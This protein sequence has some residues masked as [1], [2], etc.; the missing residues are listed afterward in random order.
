MVPVSGAAE[1]DPGISTSDY[2]YTEIGLTNAPSPP[3]DGTW[4][5]C[6]LGTCDEMTV[7]APAP[8]EAAVVLSSQDA[9]PNKVNC[10]F[11]ISVRQQYD[12][13]GG[14]YDPAPTYTWGE[15]IEPNRVRAAA[16]GTVFTITPNLTADTG[17]GLTLD[18][19]TGEISGTPAD[20]S[21]PVSCVRSCT[22]EES[23]S[24]SLGLTAVGLGRVC[25][26]GTDDWEICSGADTHCLS[27][28]Y[29]GTL[30]RANYPSV[31][32]TDYF[33]MCGDEN[34]CAS[35]HTSLTGDGSWL[36]GSNYDGYSYAADS[37]SCNVTDRSASAT[38]T[39]TVTA[40]ND[41]GSASAAIT[42]TIVPPLPVLSSSCADPENVTIG[43]ATDLNCFAASPHTTF[44]TDP[45]LPWA[46]VMHPHTGRIN[47]TAHK[48]SFPDYLPALTSASS[49]PPVTYTVRATNAAGEVTTP[50]NLT[51]ALEPPLLNYSKN[52][53]GVLKCLDGADYECT[54]GVWSTLLKEQSIGD[55]SQNVFVANWG[56]EATYSIQ[57]LNQPG[58]SDLPDGLELSTPYPWAPGTQCEKTFPVLDQGA[59][60]DSS[61]RS[62]Q[63]LRQCHDTKP[64]EC[65]Q[66]Y[67]TAT[68]SRAR[69]TYRITARNAAGESTIDVTFEVKPISRN[70]RQLG[71]RLPGHMTDAGFHNVVGNFE[72]SFSQAVNQ[73]LNESRIDR[74]RIAS[75]DCASDCV[76]PACGP[77]CGRIEPYGFETLPAQDGIGITTLIRFEICGGDCLWRKAS[78]QDPVYKDISSVQIE[79]ALRTVIDTMLGIPNLMPADAGTAKTRRSTILGAELLNNSAIGSGHTGNDIVRHS[80]DG[81]SYWTDRYGVANVGLESGLITFG[82]NYNKE[83]P[84]TPYLRLPL[85]D[86]A[87]LNTNEIT[88]TQPM[89]L[90]WKNR[91]LCIDDPNWCSPPI[92]D[93]DIETGC[94]DNVADPSCVPVV[95]CKGGEEQ[96]NELGCGSKYVVRGDCAD[97]INNGQED[98][99]KGAYPGFCLRQGDLAVLMSDEP[100]DA[101]NT[102]LDPSHDNAEH[103]PRPSSDLVTSG[104]SAGPDV[105]GSNYPISLRP[106]VTDNGANP[107][108]LDNADVKFG[109]I[110]FTVASMAEGV[111]LPRDAKLNI[112]LNGKQY[113]T[114]TNR[115]LTQ[116]RENTD[117]DGAILGGVVALAEFGPSGFQYVNAET[118]T[119]TSIEPEALPLRRDTV[120]T[121]TGTTFQT[122]EANVTVFGSDGQYIGQFNSECTGQGTTQRVCDL[123]QLGESTY[124]N[125][126]RIEIKAS[127][128]QTVTSVADS[129]PPSPPPPS[130]SP[131]P[132]EAGSGEEGSGSGFDGGLEDEEPSP[133]AP[134]P[135]SAPPEAREYSSIL[136][137][138]ESA[139]GTLY[140]PPT[141]SSFQPTVAPV[142]RPLLIAVHGSGFERFDS[143]SR[144][145]NPRPTPY[146]GFRP[147]DDEHPD[148][149]LSAHG[150]SDGGNELG[151]KVTWV[152]ALHSGVEENTVCGASDPNCIACNV[153]EQ[154]DSAQPYAVY[155]SLNA[156]EENNAGKGVFWNGVNDTFFVFSRETFSPYGTVRNAS[157]RYDADGEPA[158]T[159]PASEVQIGLSGF[160]ND[161]RSEA[162]PSSNA[163][164][165]FKDGTTEEIVAASAVAGSDSRLR[166]LS[167]PW[168][169]TGNIQ[170]DVSLDD[171]VTFSSFVTSCT[172]DVNTECYKYYDSPVVAEVVPHFGPA[173]GGAIIKLKNNMTLLPDGFTETADGV[174]CQF[175]TSNPVVGTRDS[176]E[177]VR[178]EAPPLSTGPHPVKVSLNGQLYTLSQRDFTSFSLS[179]SV[180]W[181][182]PRNQ[183]TN[184]TG[185]ITGLSTLA[186]ADRPEN[187]YC[188]FGG[189]QASDEKAVVSAE[190]S[191]DAIQIRCTAPDVE[192]TCSDPS[193][194]KAQ[195]EVEMSGYNSS[196]TGTD[197]TSNRQK[198]QYYDQPV[199]GTVMPN[200]TNSLG[201]G[202]VEVSVVASTSEGIKEHV[203]TGGEKGTLKC[204]F[205]PVGS[206]GTVKEAVGTAKDDGRAVRCQQPELTSAGEYTVEVSLNDQQ[207]TTGGP[208]LRAFRIAPLDSAVDGAVMPRG[209]P[210][211]SPINVRFKLQGLPQNGQGVS[212]FCQLGN[213]TLPINM[214]FAGSDT[215]TEGLALGEPPTLWDCQLP[216]LDTGMVGLR[217]LFLS[218]DADYFD[219]DA[220]PS[221]PFH[222]YDEPSVYSLSPTVV[223]GAGTGVDAVY[224]NGSFPELLGDLADSAAVRCVFGK[225]Q[226]VEIGSGNPPAD[227]EQVAIGDVS[228]V[229]AAKLNVTGG[230]VKCPITPHAY[231]DVNVWVTLDGAS[232]YPRPDGFRTN[233]D[234][235]VEYNES[236]DALQ[237]EYEGCPQG[238]FA[239]QPC[240]NVAEC[241]DAP[242]GAY[243]DACQPCPPGMYTQEKNQYKCITCDV[244]FYTNESGSS[245]Q[246][247]C[248]A[249]SEIEDENARVARENC[250]CKQGFF[251]LQ[252]SGFYIGAEV[253]AGQACVACSPH[254]CELG[255]DFC[256]DCPGKREQPRPKPG[257]WVR[258]LPEWTNNSYDCFR[259]WTD[260]YGFSVVDGRRIP[261][262]PIP[263]E[264]LAGDGTCAEPPCFKL[265][266]FLKP[267][268]RPCAKVVGC[269]A[270]N[271]TLSADKCICKGYQL[272]CTA[273]LGCV[274]IG[275]G[276]ATCHDGYTGTLCSACQQNYFEDQHGTCQPCQGLDRPVIIFVIM[277]CVAIAAG[278]GC[279]FVAI[280][281]A[282][283]DLMAGRK[284]FGAFT[285]GITFWQ[286]VTVFGRLALDWPT[287]VESA[288]D[289][290]EQIEVLSQVDGFVS[291]AQCALTMKPLIKLILYMI[292]PAIFLLFIVCCFW[293]LLVNERLR[294]W[295]RHRS[296]H[297][298]RRH[299][300][301]CIHAFM[302][303]LNISYMMLSRKALSVFDCGWNPT[304]QR[305]EMEGADATDEEVYFCDFRGGTK[306]ATNEWPSLVAV[307]AAGAIVWMVGIP[308]IYLYQLI[309]HRKYIVFTK[310]T[311]AQMERMARAQRAGQALRGD[312]S[313]AS[314]CGYVMEQCDRFIR[315]LQRETAFDK[316]GL[317]PPPPM[318]EELSA[319][320]RRIFEYLQRAQ[321]EVDARVRAIAAE[322]ARERAAG[323]RQDSPDYQEELRS[324]AKGGKGKGRFSMFK[325]KK[326]IKEKPPELYLIDDF[327]ALLRDMDEVTKLRSRFGFLIGRWSP[328]CFYWEILLMTRK[329]MIAVFSRFLSSHTVI[330]AI[331]C[332]VVVFAAWSLQLRFEPFEL[333]ADNRLEFY[334]MLCCEL[335][336]F[337]GVL[338][339]QIKQIRNPYV[340]YDDDGN[341]LEEETCMEQLA[342]RNQIQWSVAPNW[343]YIRET[344]GYA[345]M[346]LLFTTSFF[347]VRAL[348]KNITEKLW[349]AVHPEMKQKIMSR[350]T[351][352]YERT[353]KPVKEAPRKIYREIFSRLRRRERLNYNKK[354]GGGGYS[355]GGGAGGAAGAKGGGGAMN[356]PAAEEA[357]Q[358]LES[359]AQ[360]KREVAMNEAERVAVEE[361]DFRFIGLWLDT[362]SDVESADPDGCTLLM[363]AAATSTEY[364]VALLIM[365][366][367][368]HNRRDSGGYTALHYACETDNVAVVEYLVAVGADVNT[369]AGNGWSCVHVAA[370]HASKPLCAAIISAGPILDLVTEDGA[371][372]EQLAEQAA[373]TPF[374]SAMRDWRQRFND[375]G[376]GGGLGRMNSLRGQRGSALG[377]AAGAAASGLGSML[378]FRPGGNNRGSAAAQS[379]AALRGGGDGPPSP[380]GRGASNY[381][382]VVP[383]PPLSNAR[384]GLSDGSRQGGL[385]GT[386][387]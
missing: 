174:R 173:D 27:A 22:I 84:S 313:V 230:Y 192:P 108:V 34:A 273:G 353:L 271:T 155:V 372:P 226:L 196:A 157:D 275:Y 77:A 36:V 298:L 60:C 305:F 362:T 197:W 216:T 126:A 286:I 308:C 366:G 285:I 252:S 291:Q 332:Q 151:T 342:K 61:A 106:E 65:V 194:C 220:T 104:Q 127:N 382:Q 363:H 302:Y 121:L 58:L 377:A 375:G 208:R 255:S 175:G 207:Y 336:L 16:D 2:E 209:S 107:C 88:G 270:A 386:T 261:N 145:L 139:N 29:V 86:A 272:N 162:V 368:Q 50:L 361:E 358:R 262:E 321:V 223:P 168:S 63:E 357:K 3:S 356:N 102:I 170:L 47:G 227:R 339:Q 97:L 281:M 159:G 335:V 269:S 140:V 24:G 204:R 48:A 260:V 378:S 179:S 206:S 268:I 66:I 264:L 81:W 135:P 288:F 152:P 334:V 111:A 188:R 90:S 13:G 156:P 6:R 200:H 167:P 176:D 250:E 183:G 316:W 37:F 240:D 267:S 41:G 14:Y 148:F 128:V 343:C 236:S 177:V 243:T 326:V 307:G 325:R 205:T 74:F 55:A 233:Y 141:V 314:T 217:R 355:G 19:N 64:T 199:A 380:P 137:S 110:K 304:E 387:I 203:K 369:Q 232:F 154:L 132:P 101:S 266:C 133:F 35:L 23:G 258:Q 277:A 56:G 115:E 91:P 345:N 259:S 371:T 254:A 95:A 224:I 149:H 213:E 338:F 289:F 164:C 129:P 318:K 46:L 201:G 350:K 51:F 229:G 231:G 130:P 113:V 241:N 235:I 290:T 306:G 5:L 329:L 311:A 215:S 186:A 256:A 165:R 341:A 238:Y 112:S 93:V 247:P 32:R 119:L 12:F 225:M 9:V 169:T 219:Y 354:K 211:G 69:M 328:V 293:L 21:S 171:N 370:V 4:Q 319:K 178:C 68:K 182:G 166:C 317:D 348:A 172:N 25:H 249:N 43:A 315:E 116:L 310:S 147:F 331:C 8:S 45:P 373:H 57:I 347:I 296:L 367:A 134:P 31:S 352:L 52:E 295:D 87:D 49:M 38:T 44:T 263:A 59:K 300:D 287:S 67:G 30:T 340:N 53:D 278:L 146:C 7:R 39:Y 359:A 265:P 301:H 163:L 379:A 202:N 312:V 103:S 131:P 144:K 324:R 376:G 99:A 198:F 284:A 246:I 138:V 297:R 280:K 189:R 80:P 327:A 385:Q 282:Q 195:V 92:P 142:G 28:R 322:N 228:D 124:D 187:V 120:V 20:P 257:H 360:N 365:K 184:V 309:R 118:P 153:E 17:G 214:T 303:F 40:T 210:A 251:G 344:I 294:Y 143:G 1:S 96:F 337:S 79:Q 239:G 75:A 384:S 117:T 248:P 122:T 351:W 26:N 274:G 70:A 349:N 383:P 94:N 333:E 83:L 54:L 244:S 76:F 221:A 374:L 72:T 346:I 276:Q 125:A 136:L 161:Y 323:G 73:A 10:S 114:M 253:V 320:A 158:A 89:T 185:T 212:V 78:N 18:R 109:C 98:V 181:G 82:D 191:S 364:M 279:F 42:M 245:E 85:K 292:L 123:I 222:V 190:L 218:L 100:A 283:I 330:A 234:D 160:K 193:R 150:T 180:P 33:R 381:S 11:V 242:P 62:E 71:I 15:T 299:L 105:T 237:L